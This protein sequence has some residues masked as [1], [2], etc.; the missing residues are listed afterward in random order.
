MSKLLAGA[1]VM[2]TAFHSVPASASKPS[3]P[4]ITAREEGALRHMVA[5]M[6]RAWKAHDADAYAAQFTD[7]AEHINAYGMWWR[8]RHEIAEAM[9]FVLNRIYPDNPITVDQVSV[10]PLTKDIAIVQYRWR[11]N[12]YEDPDG[13]KH[14][15]PAGADHP[16]G[17]ETAS[18]MADSNVPEHVYQS[19]CQAG[20]VNPYVGFPTILDGALGLCCHRG[21]AQLSSDNCLIEGDFI[22]FRSV[23][24]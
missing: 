2:V 3:P 5:D 15:N 1:F 13:T 20:S 17:R 12:S 11:L 10:Q 19:E 16:G 7:N 8:G 21:R 4:T 22:R 18:R 9:K 14:V 23:A 24:A 6:E